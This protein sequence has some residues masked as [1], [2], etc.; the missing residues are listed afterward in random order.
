MIPSAFAYHAPTSLDEAISL[1]EHY[2]DEAKLLA[3]G[4]SLLPAMK[5]R[6]AAPAVLIDLGRI[7]GLGDIRLNGREGPLM[8]GAMATWAQIEQHPGLRA[9]LPVLGETVSL[10]GD[11]QVRN[12]GTLGGALAHADPAGDAS[13]LMLALEARLHAQG[14]AGAR[15]IAASEFFTDMLVTALAPGEILTMIEL[16]PLAPGAGAAYCKLAHPASRYA[17]VGVAAYLRLEGEVVRACRVAVTG[18]GPRPERQ[19]AVEQAMLGATADLATI[20]HAAALAGEG[21]ELLGDMHA[22]AEYRLAML[23]VY[24][25][26]ALI[27]AVRRAR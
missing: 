8:I 27:E 15:T 3:G 7:A 1:I 23:K 25:R 17:T 13:A 19:P 5:L 26:R 22:S 11:I 21:M 4:H 6:L 20:A 14:M 18:A 9:A 10:I 2:G 12:R 24:T 16:E